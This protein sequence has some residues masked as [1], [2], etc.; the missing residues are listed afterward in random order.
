MSPSFLTEKYRLKSFNSGKITRVNSAPYRVEMYNTEFMASFIFLN[1]LL[2]RI[3]LM[4]IIKDVDIPNYPSK[5]Y[6]EI[7]RR[8]CTEILCNE[9]GN[10]NYSDGLCSI[11]KTPKYKISCCSILEGKDKYCSGNIFISFMKASC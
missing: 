4:P 9:Y 8:Y 2:E 7:K 6:Q 10:P 3:I 11:W 1:N 5:E